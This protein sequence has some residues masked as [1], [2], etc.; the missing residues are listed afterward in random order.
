MPTKL[1]LTFN[2]F[3]KIHDTNIDWTKTILVQRP[4]S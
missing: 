1:K 3:L 4:L 2:T